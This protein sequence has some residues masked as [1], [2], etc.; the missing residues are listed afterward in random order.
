MLKK[1][2]GM[3]INSKH[4]FVVPATALVMF[5]AVS[6]SGTRRSVES[7]DLKLEVNDQMHTKVTGNKCNKPLMNGFQASEYVVTGSDTLRDFMLE[8]T[9]TGKT[10]D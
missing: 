5:L 7:G 3:K 9:F 4:L 10:D 2:S 8:K 6:C 1:S